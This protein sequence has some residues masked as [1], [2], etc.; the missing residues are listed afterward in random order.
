MP[1]SPR[2]T[3]VIT[4]P[5]EQ[6]HTLAQ[7][8]HTLGLTPQV[9]PL[10]EIRPVADSAPLAAALSDLSRYALVVFVSPNAVTHAMACLTQVAQRSPGDV[11]PADVPLAVVG[12]ASAL[13]LAEHGIAPPRHRIVQPAGSAEE[14]RFDSEGLFARLDMASL[15]GKEVL[16]VRGNGGREWL[17]DQLRAGGATVTIV[18]AYQRLAPQPSEADWAAV[19]AGLQGE[20]PVRERQAWLLTSSEAVRYLDTLARE[21]LDATD[22]ARLREVQCFAPHARIIEQARA[23]G[24]THLQLTGAGD[25]RLLAA[26]AAWAGINQEE[27]AAAQR[28]P[29]SASSASS[30]STSSPPRAPAAQT[31]SAAAGMSGNDMHANSAASSTARPPDSRVEHVTGTPSTATSFRPSMMRWWFVLV[32]IAVLAIGGL[33]WMQKRIDSL[34]GELARRQQANDTLVQEARVLSREAQE[35]AKTLQAKVG[36]L[37]TQITEARQHQVA[38]E[39]LYQDFTRNRD[40]WELAEVEQLLNSASQ[41]LQLTGNLQAALSAAQSA[42]ARL[43]RAD[44]PRY[45]ALRRALARDIERMKDVPSTDIIGAAIK[46]DEAILQI[47]TLPLLSGE[48][49][50]ER[51]PRPTHAAKPAA[52]PAGKSAGNQGVGPTAAQ[53]AEAAAGSWRAHL[54]PVGAWFAAVWADVRDDVL[55]LIQVRRV[56]HT[57]AMLLSADQG[58]FLRENLKLRLLNARLALLARNDAS[59]RGDLEIANKLLVKYFDSKSR[60]VAS[61][62][63]L[64]KQAQASAVSVTLPTLAESMDALRA[65]KRE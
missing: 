22:L 5:R 44:K 26:V 62:Q 58:W 45:K 59:F 50:L 13:T 54:A 47:D 10:L 23:L 61:V 28:M 39:Q 42:D 19:R 1:T 49:T 21:T 36:G 46:L 40:D 18:E 30:A 27:A 25:T 33:W 7:G 29:S 11:W 37:E 15:Q 14:A 43:A 57:E 56:E 55:G 65:L 31:M 51:E 41:Q 53:E 9:F 6:S 48:T 16:I 32:L 63:L 20:G 2:P 12:P 35:S 3:V 64:L 8:V 4:R 34:T 60:R 38:L 52:P 24:F 17:A